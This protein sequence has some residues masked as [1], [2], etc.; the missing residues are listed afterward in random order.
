MGSS[1]KTKTNSSGVATRPRAVLGVSRG[2][3]AGATPTARGK[4]KSKAK[5]KD[6]AKGK[7]K[8]KDEDQFLDIRQ[9]LTEFR[10]VNPEWY[11]YWVSSFIEDHLNYM[12]GDLLRRL[13]RMGTEGQLPEDM[14]YLKVNL[15]ELTRKERS[16]DEQI[17]MIKQFCCNSSIQDERAFQAS[18]NSENP[19]FG[20]PP[21]RLDYLV[22]D[23]I[24]ALASSES[25]YQAGIDCVRF[26]IEL[27]ILRG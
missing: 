15:G 5:A 8:T 10:A 19:L 16:H 7:T 2:K 18:L 13:V 3:R 24:S 26:Q 4:A 11:P 25:L 27:K 17:K 22:D 20:Y 21:M 12:E 9:E 23:F 6:K 1:S 14:L